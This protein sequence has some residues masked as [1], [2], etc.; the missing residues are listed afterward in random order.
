MAFT[1]MS[2]HAGQE[3]INLFGKIGEIHSRFLK[4]VMPPVKVFQ[5]SFDTSQAPINDVKAPVDAVQA[6]IDAIEAF[7]HALELIEH[8]P[9]EPF[10]TV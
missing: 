8:Q 5:L 3:M 9:A 2:G 1:C 10:Q 6:I 4:R 7:L